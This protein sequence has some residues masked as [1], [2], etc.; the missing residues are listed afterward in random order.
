MAKPPTQRN[1]RG[2]AAAPGVVFR[3]RAENRGR[4]IIIHGRRQSSWVQALAARARPATPGAGVLPHLRVF[5]LMPRAP[6]RKPRF[7]PTATGP[8][9]ARRTQKKERG[10]RRQQNMPLPLRPLSV[11]AH[12]FARPANG[13]SRELRLA[14]FGHNVPHK[15]AALAGKAGVSPAATRTAAKSPNSSAN[16]Q[17]Q[18]ATAVASP[19]KW[20]F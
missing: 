16:R 4:T 9:R 12:T 17:N 3:A 6:R 5:G 10:L 15:L 19:K 2:S 13:G 14:R 8:R 7:R 18:P 11:G 20:S 1:G